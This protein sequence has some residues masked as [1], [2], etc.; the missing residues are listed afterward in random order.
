MRRAAALLWGTALFAA[1][2]SVSS[3]ASGVA[4]DGVGF[5]ELNRGGCQE[6][7]YDAQRLALFRDG[8]RT[9][10]EVLYLFE[11]L[12][13]SWYLEENWPFF[14][15]LVSL[16]YRSFAK[17]EAWARQLYDECLEQGGIRRLAWRI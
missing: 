1:T 14:L 2:L 4:D 12:R 7:G 17:P 8:G 11:A 15:D 10:E 5:R 9:T 3:S 16:T 13:V 6:Y